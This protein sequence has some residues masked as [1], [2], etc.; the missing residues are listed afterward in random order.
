MKKQEP[1]EDPLEAI[2]TVVLG[3]VIDGDGYRDEDLE[4]LL[5]QLDKKFAQF[6]DSATV[7]K[8]LCFLCMEIVA[9]FASPERQYSGE[10][11]ER[12]DDAYGRLFTAVEVGLF[13]QSDD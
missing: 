10:Q 8:E 6:H 13:S 11:V 5:K 3:G 12:M 1:Q 9:A 2:A 4:E 7:P